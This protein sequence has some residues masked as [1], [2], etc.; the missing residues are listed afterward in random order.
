MIKMKKI[1]PL[2]VVSALAFSP[3]TKADPAAGKQSQNPV[4]A[5]VGDQ[6]IYFLDVVERKKAIPQLE[7]ASI[8]AVYQGLVQQMV[9]E[10][11]LK[12]EVAKSTIDN[13]PEYKERVKK[14]QEAAKMQLFVEKKIEEM[15]TD[16]KLMELFNKVKKEFKPQDEVDAHHIL[17]ED[18]KEAAKILSQLKNG[19]NFEALAREKSTDPSTKQRGGKLGYF[20]KDVAKAT[21]G[22]NFAETVFLLKPGHHSKVKSKFGWHVIMV[23]DKRKSKPP[24]FEQA[25]PQLRMLQSQQSLLSYIEKLM[26]EKKVK[27]FDTKGKEIEWDKKKAKK[28]ATPKA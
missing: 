6:N 9:A 10:M 11:L 19:G 25:A 15:V 18:E 12:D 28:D 4:V 26:K 20:T 7:S 2:A 23:K 13:T 14:C 1:F 22:P 5:K 21:L 16:E 24:K 3:V 17:V 8:D 27:L